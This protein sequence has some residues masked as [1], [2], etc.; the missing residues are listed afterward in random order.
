MGFALA[1]EAATLGADVTVVA[2]NVTLERDPRV[3]YLDV[4]T[5]QE[6]EDACT[7]AFA[8]TDILLMAA[9]V[10]D[11]RPANPIAG[12]L[13]KGSGEELRLDL[14]R[15][16]DILAGLASARRPGQTIVGFAAEHGEGGVQEGRNK[17]ARKRVDA[18]VV[19]DIS[20]T[21]IGFD[22]SDNEVTIVTAA[23][24]THVALAS[25]A[26]VA[27]A[28]LDTVLRLRTPA[29]TRETTGPAA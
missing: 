9:A 12:K 7:A 13:K 28:V 21:D 6:L 15:T 22:A 16:P 3:R 11:F 10:V 20:R 25:K 29:A 17:L 27:R 2:A 23:G 4:E 24:E 1:H 19:N 18:I 5:A 14:D 8:D 26:A